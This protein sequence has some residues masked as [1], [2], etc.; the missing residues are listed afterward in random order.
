L[1]WA[2]GLIFYVWLTQETKLSVKLFTPRKL[3]GVV[4]LGAKLLIGESSLLSGLLSQALRKENS[5]SKY[6]GTREVEIVSILI[7]SIFFI[8]G[9]RAS[10]SCCE[11][12]LYGVIFNHASITPL[13]GSEVSSELLE[14]GGSDLTLSG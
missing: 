10:Y 4:G 12:S 8:G 9:F 11:V 2:L 1:L 3:G 5:C 6:V 7:P 14:H 13:S